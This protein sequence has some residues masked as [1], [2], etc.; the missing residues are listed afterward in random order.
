LRAFD[1]R[2]RVPT[3]WLLNDWIWTCNGG[4]PPAGYV[5]LDRDDPPTFESQASY[6]RG[7][8]LLWP[9]K[10]ADLVNPDF[11]PAPPPASTGTT[12]EGFTRM[13]RAAMADSST[14]AIVINVDSPGGTIY[15]I[16]ELSQ[17]IFKAR[18]QKRIVRDR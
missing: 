18:G 17:E 1:L 2:L 8:K 13:F 4:K 9:G 15:G 16:D 11:R 7:L 12:T 10:R 5:A 6:L 14:K 3:D